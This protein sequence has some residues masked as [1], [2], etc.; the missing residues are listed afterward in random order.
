MRNSEDTR[1]FRVFSPDENN[2]NRLNAVLEVT[3]RAWDAKVEPYD[4]PLVPDGRVMEIL[5]EH[6]CQGWL[7]G[8]LLTG[9]HGLLSCL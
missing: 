7:E 5:S 9:R 6:M 4:D 2:S 8:Y 1:N 3:G